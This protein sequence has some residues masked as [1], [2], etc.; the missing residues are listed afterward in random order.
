MTQSNLEFLQSLINVDSTNPPANENNVVQIFKQRCASRNIPFD[1]TH[2]SDKRSNFSVT[3]KSE[4]P[5]ASKLLLSGHTDTVKI[6]AQ[7]WDYDPFKGDI[8]HGKLY[9]R[10]TTDMKSGLA[11]LY[12]ALESLIEENYEFKKILNF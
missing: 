9:G 4:H 11:A 5:N 7:K 6:G 3:L 2:L 10:G 12:L 8:A 1:I